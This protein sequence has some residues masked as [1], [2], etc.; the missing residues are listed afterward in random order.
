[1]NKDTRTDWL[2]RQLNVA[3]REVLRPADAH[4]TRIRQRIHVVRRVVAVMGTLATVVSLV[5]WLMIAVLGAGLDR[6][7]WLWAVPPTLLAVGALTVADR[8]H[9]G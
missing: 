8:V 3:A 1:M 6:P 5:V 4:H 9:A 7:W 2:T